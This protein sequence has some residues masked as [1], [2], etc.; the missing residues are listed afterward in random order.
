[1]KLVKNNKNDLTNLNDYIKTPPK[2]SVVL[3]FT[4]K[5][6][7]YVLTNLNLHNRPRKT[8][9][10]VQYSKDMT[11]HN[12]LIT[13]ETIAFGSDGLLKDGQ[14]RLAACIRANTS[15]DTHVIFGIDPRAFVVMDTG[16]NR[17]H[18]DVLAIMG[19]KNAK[20]ISATIRLIS[21][22]QVGKTNTGALKMTNEE[23]KD[24]YLN[25]M[26]QE[27]LQ[28]SVLASKSVYTVTSINVTALASIYYLASIGG[29]EEKVARFLEHLRDGYGG[30]RSP[31]KMFM[32]RLNE[33]KTNP[34]YK[35]TS[36]DIAIL[37]TRTWYNYKHN[38]Q[39]TKSD[40]T[41]LLSDK[42]PAI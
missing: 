24:C 2:N 32:K 12:W 18:S 29:C 31:Q 34:S 27:L 30:A 19:V 4:P 3:T 28:R 37:L 10:I 35:I 23:I 16:A 7:E 42:I 26:D 41:V 21:A 17:S 38:K 13:G 11:N 40:M 5:L 8:A 36:H 25:N 9:K 33:L 22:W 39:S 1:M 15:F 20:R 14:N 6:A